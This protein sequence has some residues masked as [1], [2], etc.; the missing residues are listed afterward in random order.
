MGKLQLDAVSQLADKMCTH[1]KVCICT[2][3][4]CSIYG[5]YM[6]Y[7]KDKLCIDI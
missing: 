5:A 6:S 7:M 3:V 1:S 4:L 2:D